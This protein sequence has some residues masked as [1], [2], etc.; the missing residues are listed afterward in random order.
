VLNV[1]AYAGISLELGNVWAQR[2][3]ISLHS[4]RRD[5]AVFFGADTYIGP[6]YLAAGYDE[7][8]NTA[9]YLFLGRSF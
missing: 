6:V 2:S 5:A 8:G 1:P 7:N 3:N 9:F 4:A